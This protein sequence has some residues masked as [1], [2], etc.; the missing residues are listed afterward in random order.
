MPDILWA[1]DQGNR[2]EIMLGVAKDSMVALPPKPPAEDMF[3][4]R[5]V[6]DGVGYAQ[7]PKSSG[8]EDCRIEVQGKSVKVGLD[9][10]STSDTAWR[11]VVNG[12][13]ETLTEAQG[14][15][16]SHSDET[17]IRQGA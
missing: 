10:P 12:Q 16:V 11:L 14:V 9:I 5:A 2:Q 4:V 6:V 7:V 15:S 3:D 17:V 8:S 13:E 1:E